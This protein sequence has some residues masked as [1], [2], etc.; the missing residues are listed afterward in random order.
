MSQACSRRARGTGRG[1]A[2]KRR[3]MRKKRAVF[4]L[5]LTPLVAAAGG[6]L[7]LEALDRRG[8]GFYETGRSVVE[9]L[10]GLGAALLAR[11]LGALGRHYAAGYR[12]HPLGLTAMGAAAERDGIRIA[13]FGA[14]AGAGLGAWEDRQGALAAWQQYLEGFGA[15]EE[16]G[17]HLD[18]LEEWAGDELVARVR[19]ELIGTPRGAARAGIDRALFRM[20][21]GRRAAAPQSPASAPPSP[22][23][24]AGGAERL[25]ILEASLLEGDRVIAEEAQF[26]DVSHAA[27]IDFENRP[28]PG[29]LAR[30]L[31]FGMI[32]YGPGGIT[33]VDYDNDGFYDLFIP[34]GV[35][36]RLLRNR[37]DGTFED[38]TEKAG[39]EGLDGV[40][41]AVFADYD[42]DGYKDLFV[43]RTFRPNQLFHNNGDGTFTDVTARSGLGEDCCT[44]VASWG[45]YDNDGYLDL[46]VGRYLDPR[47][48]IPTTFYARNGEPN[49]LYHNNGDGT[50]TDVTERAGVGDTGLCLGSAWGDYDGDGRLDLFVVNDFGRSTLY[51]NRGDGTFADVTAA[52]G[53]L[54][55][56]AGM[57][58]SFGDYDNDGRL[59]L[60]TADI[61][62]EHGWY[63]APPTVGRYMANSWKQGVWRTDMPLYWQI[64]RQSGLDF[65]DVFREMAA[66]NHLLRNRGDG[67]FEDV[68]VKAGANPIGWF[69]GSVFADFD[70]DGWLDIYS[71]DGWVYGRRGT[72]IELE[73]LNNVVSRQREYKTGIFFDP[74]NF[75]DLSWHGWERNRHLRNN[76]DGTFQEIG[77]GAGT[78]MIAN[79][80]GVA[81]ADF[82]NRG[83]LDLAIAASGGRHMLL[84][85]EVAPRHHWL[86]VELTGTRSNRDAVGARVEVEAGG[87]RQLREVS[88]GDGY[89]SQSALRLHFGLGEA[90]TADLVTVRWPA[91]GRV[92]RFAG[93]AADRIVALTEGSGRLVEKRYGAPRR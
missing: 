42:N 84:R 82:W 80:R 4:G 92:E 72:E 27:G 17:F 71:A 77:R 31:R 60:Y 20:R 79:S 46:Y 75:G 2:E 13:R 54:A 44:T 6:W 78:D 67:T 62:S 26:T 55:Y 51:R 30:S 93:V 10:D 34:D 16:A 48:D 37:G 18:R 11:D 90:A 8:R 3:P 33:A 85:N 32:R 66:G 58:A 87:R 24:A 69:W 68:A 15:I 57:S 59:D 74:K 19:F 5:A 40:S 9:G 7:G 38:V 73:F 70:N 52:A 65:V 47:R 81:V 14:G 39:L 76:G 35:S 91:S 56:G 23:A 21:F 83:A 49:R 61:R 41:V 88:A 45:D 64:F 1:A 43:S 53:A 29:F 22:G 50:F 12:G 86:Q 63:A 36:S 25:E 89:A 28:Y